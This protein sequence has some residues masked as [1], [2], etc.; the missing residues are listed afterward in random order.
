LQIKYYPESNEFESFS[1]TKEFLEFSGYRPG[2]I[3]INNQIKELTNFSTYF[4][5]TLD[6]YSTIKEFIEGNNYEVTIQKLFDSLELL[7]PTLGVTQKEFREVLESKDMVKIIEF[8][9]KIKQK[10]LSHI[11]FLE[12]I[13]MEP[14]SILEVFEKALDRTLRKT[15]SNKETGFIRNPTQAQV[16][17]AKRKLMIKNSDKLTLQS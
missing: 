14:S 6:N 3:T 8:E 4:N 9:L 13:K 2:I 10:L 16:L 15:S 17:K 7:V 5:H 12:K 11:K 1:V